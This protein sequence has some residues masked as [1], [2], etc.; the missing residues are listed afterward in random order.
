[1]AA[2]QAAESMAPTV[3]A[4]MTNK[5]NAAFAK[6]ISHTKST[7]GSKTVGA[8]GTRLGD[9]GC[10]WGTRLGGSIITIMTLSA[11]GFPKGTGNLAVRTCIRA[12]LRTSLILS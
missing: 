4:G 3:S 5:L 1:M 7:S 6:N 2:C 8:W 10:A 12:M 9:G 11:A